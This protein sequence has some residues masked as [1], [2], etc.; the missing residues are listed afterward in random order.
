VKK[1]KRETI[2]TDFIYV[3]TASDDL[4][5]KSCEYVNGLKWFPNAKNYMSGTGPF[6]PKI[7]ESKFIRNFFNECLEEV[8]KDLKLMCPELKATSIWANKS[9]KRN[10]HHG[11]I[12]PNSW[13]SGIFYLTPSGSTTWMSRDHFWKTDSS[14]GSVLDIL[15]KKGANQIYRCKSEPGKLVIFPSHLWHSVNE[16]DTNNP[17][18]TISFNSF[19]SGTMSVG[20]KSTTD[21]TVINLKIE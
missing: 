8:R 4:L 6:S 16:H 10:W 21:L 20:N 12:H 19:P 2:F 18:Y 5:K 1:L 13:A 15:M 3:F 11:H 9:H 17:R 7:E 14:T